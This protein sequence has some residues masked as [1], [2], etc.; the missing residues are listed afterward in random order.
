[1][2][3]TYSTSVAS[4]PRP[5]KKVLV[6][7]SVVLLFLIC[8]FRPQK[9][10]ELFFQPN[11]WDILHENVMNGLLCHRDN[12][13]PTTDFG[14]QRQRCQSPVPVAYYKKGPAG[15]IQ[16]G[17][18]NLHT[19]INPFMNPAELLSSGVLSFFSIEGIDLFRQ[20][21]ERNQCQC[22]IFSAASQ[23]DTSFWRS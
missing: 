14:T 15:E 10:R 13:Q 6:S 23:C 16:R 5:S 3:V 8:D 17:F 18:F 1:M 9:Y 11:F 21:L 7:L 20:C 22:C 12:Y 2:V 4:T 19:G